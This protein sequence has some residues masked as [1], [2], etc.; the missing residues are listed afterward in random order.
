MPVYAA[1]FSGVWLAGH[2]LV[3]ANTRLEAKKLLLATLDTKHDMPSRLSDG[4]ERVRVRDIK[5]V[6]VNSSGTVNVLWDGDY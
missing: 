6:D 5:E 3:V 4:S 2:A 1:Q